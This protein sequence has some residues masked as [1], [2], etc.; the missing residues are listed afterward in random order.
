VIDLLVVVIMS[1]EE[2]GLFAIWTSQKGDG[3]DKS[4]NFAAISGLPRSCSS[5]ARPR[6]KRT[7]WLWA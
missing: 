1:S 2:I 4:H 5:L 6:L 7:W 3:V